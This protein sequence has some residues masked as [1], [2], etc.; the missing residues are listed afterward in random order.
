V[1]AMPSVWT[2]ASLPW[3]PTSA[4]IFSIHAI[5]CS[6]MTCQPTSLKGKRRVIESLKAGAGLGLFQWGR[7]E[8]RHK[9]MQPTRAIYGNIVGG[10]RVSVFKV[11][12]FGL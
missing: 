11:V 6:A 1:H 5:C 12:S 9:D 8:K 4:K 3:Q 10:E 2:R 7:E